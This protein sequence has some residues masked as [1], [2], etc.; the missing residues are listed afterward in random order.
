M[1]ISEADEKQFLG[2][3]SRTMGTLTM[4]RGD[5]WW[6]VAKTNCTILRCM[7]PHGKCYIISLLSVIAN[8]SHLLSWVT[9]NFIWHASPFHSGPFHVTAVKFIHK[10]HH[11]WFCWVTL[12]VE[13]WDLKVPP[14]LHYIDLLWHVFLTQTSLEQIYSNGSS[15]DRVYLKKSEVPVPLA[16]I[17]ETWM[18]S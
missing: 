6:I 12:R 8:G 7:L 9:M 3:K 13:N 17:G 15:H 10:I 18:S 2:V 14:F 16:S 1:S 4:R 11:R 5:Q